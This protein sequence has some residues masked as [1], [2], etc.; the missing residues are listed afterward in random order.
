MTWRLG[1]ARIS[2]DRQMGQQTYEQELRHRAAVEL[3][4][5]WTV[6]DI[7]VRTLRSPLDGTRRL[8]SRLLVD[9][10]PGLRRAAGRLLYRGHDVIHRLDLRLPPAPACEVLTIHDMAPWRFSDEGHTPP[11]AASSAR[12]AAVV[13]CPSQ[14]AADEVSW[15]LGVSDPVSIHNGVNADF[16]DATPLSHVG[17]DALGIRQPFILHA[18]GCTGRKNLAGLA[19]AWPT[20]RRERPDVS[21][22]LMGPHDPRRSELFGPLDGT[23]CI[24]MIIDELVARIMAAATVVVVPS[25]Y[26]GFGLPALE[27][28]ATGVPV[29]ASD[30]SSLPEVCGNAALLVE[31]DATGLAGGLIAALE[32]GPEVKAMIARGRERAASFTWEASIAA[33]G[34]LWRSCIS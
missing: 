25:T 32:R 31:P 12:R 28:M 30:R 2:A 19:A 8:P 5:E 34:A 7:A 14:Y 17:L 24:G 20:V 22:V 13:I 26:E 6:D 9:A 29:V 27:A 23:V 10:A 11:D 18:G 1:L 3:G 4:R 16:F 33:H 15:R 21:L